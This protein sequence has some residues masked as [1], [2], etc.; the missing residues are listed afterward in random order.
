L[1]RKWI[2]AL[3]LAGFLWL[4]SA[5]S[6]LFA[7]VPP[8]LPAGADPARAAREVFQDPD[9]WWKRIERP[10][11]STSWLESIL[12]PL[13][14]YCRQVLRRIAEL[15]WEFF[16]WLFSLFTGAGAGSTVLIWLLVAVLF[17]IAA[18]RLGPVIA[19]WLSAI[20]RWLSGRAPAP[21][22]D[23]GAAWQP[24]A[25]ASGLLEQSGAA[26]R[27]GKY[28]DAIRLALLALIARLEKQGLLRY[29]TTRTNREYQFEL[30]HRSD[31]AACFGQLA[32]IYER[33][34]YG[35]GR[36]DRA[37]A[38]HAIGLVESVINGEGLAP[39]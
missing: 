5:P 30:R 26:F 15:I 20:A 7:S 8:S 9:F 18:W 35:R 4:A 2:A 39:E 13:V 11:M 29:D 10:R 25:E 16:R 33:I 27:D 1:E 34:W 19:R 37:D 22:A 6:Q 3:P 32:R 38:E 31:L 24:L 12:L 14:D 23:A 28:A 21:S 36:A 17:A